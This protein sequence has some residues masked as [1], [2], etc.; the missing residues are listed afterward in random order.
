MNSFLTA[1]TKIRGSNKEQLDDRISL[2]ANLK[3]GRKLSGAS[4]LFNYVI[5]SHFYLETL[6]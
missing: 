6:S 5:S 2:K 4:V 3:W 1:Y